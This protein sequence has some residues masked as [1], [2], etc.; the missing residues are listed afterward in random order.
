[1]K[2]RHGYE[3]RRRNR[4]PDRHDRWIWAGRF[5]LAIGRHARDWREL[6]CW[7]ADTLLKEIY[8]DGRLE[9]VLWFQDCP[10][11]GLLPKAA[12]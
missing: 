1:M 9:Q 12:S 11:L 5:W 10:L 7:I 3:M 2:R 6:Q 4:F 8:G